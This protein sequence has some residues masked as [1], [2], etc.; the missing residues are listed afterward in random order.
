MKRRQ[1]TGQLAAGAALWIC[2]PQVRAVSLSEA[3]ARAGL[4]AALERGADSAVALLGRTDGFLGNPKVRIALPAGLDHAG[5]LMRSLG[6]GDKVDELTTAMNRAAEAAVPQSRQLLRDAVA[7]MS[8]SDAR[9][10]LTGGDTSVTRFF[11]DRTRKPLSAKFLP[12][13]TAQTEKVSLSAKYNAVAGRAAGFGLVK[14]DDANV[15]RYVTDKALDGLY[16]MIGEEE[17]RIR[18]DPIGTGNDLLK[19][20]FGPR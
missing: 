12:I 9:K 4:K 2:A 5:T 15:Q 8:V 19:K 20:V 6:Q 3:D 17:R 16:L 10:I 11:A 14:A 13:V 18:R 1:F 7:Q